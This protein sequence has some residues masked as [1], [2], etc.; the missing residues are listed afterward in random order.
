L[1]E[2]TANKLPTVYQSFSLPAQAGTVVL[3][4]L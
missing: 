2:A 3:T 1:I 4:L